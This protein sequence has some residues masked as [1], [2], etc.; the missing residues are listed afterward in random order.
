MK[1]KTVDLLENFKRGKIIQREIN[2]RG[3][4]E[5]LFTP[6]NLEKQALTHLTASHCIIV[7]VIASDRYSFLSTN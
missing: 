2:V 1:L 5:I 4:R 6:R 7:S 3:E